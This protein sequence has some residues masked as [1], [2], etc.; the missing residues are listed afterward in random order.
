MMY[1]YSSQIHKNG[2]KDLFILKELKQSHLS[3]KKIGVQ[4]KVLILVGLM[5]SRLNFG[6]VMHQIMI[7]VQTINYITLLMK[8]LNTLTLHGYIISIG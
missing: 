6:V 8:A 2:L 5:I 3:M 1:V 4:L 7:V